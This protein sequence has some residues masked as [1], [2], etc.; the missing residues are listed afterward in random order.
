MRKYLFISALM[1]FCVGGAWSAGMSMDND[2]I[3]GT[4]EQRH[5]GHVAFIVLASL[6]GS[7]SV[8]TAVLLIEELPIRVSR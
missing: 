8:C 1:V 5:A 6:F 3:V 2:R 7:C 4:P